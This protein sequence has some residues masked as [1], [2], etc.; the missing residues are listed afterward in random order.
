M[1]ITPC[2][3]CVCQEFHE[4]EFGQT[5]D[6]PNNTRWWAKFDQLFFLR[7]EVS[8]ID[9]TAG[10]ETVLRVTERSVSAEYCKETST[11]LAK[12]LNDKW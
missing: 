11:K 7:N 9:E 5:V 2:L 4:T 10:L 1:F 12:I 6:V 3:L 8:V